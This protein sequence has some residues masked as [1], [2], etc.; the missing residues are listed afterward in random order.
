MLI[1]YSA[2]VYLKSL[3]FVTS[4][5]S[6]NSSFKEEIYHTHDLL[7]KI[8]VYENGD[9]LDENYYL[10]IQKHSLHSSVS[11]PDSIANILI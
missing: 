8:Y 5:K 1:A 9:S 6:K 3:C 2:C 10:E 7:N 4:F 11:T